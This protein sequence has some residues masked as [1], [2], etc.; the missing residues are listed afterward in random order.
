[1]TILHELS[2]KLRLIRQ[3]IVQGSPSAIGRLQVQQQQQQGA[4]QAAAA[5][6]PQVVSAAG[7]AIPDRASSVVAQANA[8]NATM[9]VAS[10]AQPTVVS[11]ANLTPGQLQAAQK[12]VS[13]S[14]G[15]QRTLVSANTGKPL[16]QQQIMQFKQQA[17][18]KKQQEQAAARARQ[19]QQQQLPQQQATVVATTSTGQKVSVA[20]TPSG[21]LAAITSAA[22]V[23]AVTVVTT[24]AGAIAGQQAKAHLI[25]QLNA[26]VGAAGGVKTST[27]NVR[28]MTEGEMK[29]ILARQQQQQQQGQQQGQQAQ[30]G[31][32]Q[33]AGAAAKAQIASIQVPAG[34]Q[35]MSAAAQQ[36]LQAGIQIQTTAGGTPVAALVKTAG[37]QQQAQ[38]QSQQQ[39]VTIPLQGMNVNAVRAAA[40][41]GGQVATA[42][43]QQLTIIHRQLLQQK[44]QQQ[45]Q[46]AAAA[47]VAAGGSVVQQLPQG[48]KGTLGSVVAAAS[49]SGGGTQLI[50]SGAAA[51][52]PNQLTQKVT[53]QQIQQLVKQAQQQQQQQQPGGG[54]LQQQQLQGIPQAVLKQAAAAGQ[55]GTVQARVIPVS[56]AGGGRGPQIQVCNHT[57]FIVFLNSIIQ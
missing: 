18:L 44:R 36:L 45:Q 28:S 32:A 8:N 40:I 42:S 43:P 55:A 13:Q 10:P 31:S 49:K 24:Q 16:T 35:P 5:V 38:Q 50:V 19:Q 30:Q 7:G 6:L 56:S 1:M 22:G 54:G 29:L 4:Q 9:V 52:G 39:S 27:A 33:H 3:V 46:A 37:G 26:P 2:S 53:V 23:S 25:R 57:A 12:I 41:R 48:A 51:G 14:G 17:I 15:I 20:V 21:Q 47:A 11:V 34:G